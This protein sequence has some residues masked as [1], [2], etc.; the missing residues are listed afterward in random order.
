MI[1]YLEKLKADLLASKK[2]TV[3]KRTVTK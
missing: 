1:V 3:K 2:R